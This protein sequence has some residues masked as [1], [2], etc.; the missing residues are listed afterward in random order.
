MLAALCL[1][2]YLDHRLLEVRLIN[3]YWGRTTH[4]TCMCV[5]VCERQD[6]YQE[7]HLFRFPTCLDIPS[8]LLTFRHGAHGLVS[9]FIDFSREVVRDEVVKNTPREQPS[10][11]G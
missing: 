9:S 5:C 3:R 4:P 10:K 11:R 1:V 7:V 6:A 2:G 8:L